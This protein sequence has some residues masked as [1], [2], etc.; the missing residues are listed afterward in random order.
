[1]K[2]NYTNST[3]EL[4]KSEAKKAGIPDS[5]A[6][7]ALMKIREKNSEYKV[8]VLPT[9]PKKIGKKNQIKSTDIERYISFH[10][11]EN[12]TIMKEYK[13]RRDAKENG[14]LYSE[15][16]FAIKKWFFQ[17]YSELNKDNNDANNIKEGA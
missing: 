5:E 7:N 14:A 2:L 11:D 6:Y 4:T 10:D 1:M 13:A 16:F 8:V 17:T 3:I 9:A 12:G 15:N